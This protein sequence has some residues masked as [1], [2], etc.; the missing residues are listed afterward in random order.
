MFSPHPTHKHLW[1]CL[2]HIYICLLYLLLYTD[3]DTNTDRHKKEY[4]QRSLLHLIY[5]QAISFDSVRIQVYP[6]PV[7]GRHSPHTDRQCR[8]EQLLPT[9]WPDKILHPK[10][11]RGTAYRDRSL[12]RPGREM[13]FIFATR[14]LQTTKQLQKTQTTVPWIQI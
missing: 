13:L 3:M 2:K 7:L 1:L 4:L 9:S 12:K 5:V 11:G 8:N 14:N 10:R 6:H